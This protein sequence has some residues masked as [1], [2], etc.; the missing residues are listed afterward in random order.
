MADTTVPTSGE[1]QKLRNKNKVEANAVKGISISKLLDEVQKASKGGIFD[2]L[3]PTEDL[4]KKLDTYKAAMRKKDSS[5]D[6]TESANRVKWAKEI[7]SKIEPGIDQHLKNL[8]SH[9]D[10]VK[11]APQMATKCGDVISKMHPDDLKPEQLKKNL[12]QLGQLVSAMQVTVETLKKEA[13]SDQDYKGIEAEIRDAKKRINELEDVLNEQSQGKIA[14]DAIASM[15]EKRQKLLES[16]F[17]RLAG[18]FQ[19]KVKDYK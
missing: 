15:W 14:D 6:D 17:K 13:P 7:E 11:R 12:I 4:Q 10:T 8:K 16:M 3:D 18:M 19:D 5:L 1:W 2:T 9:Y